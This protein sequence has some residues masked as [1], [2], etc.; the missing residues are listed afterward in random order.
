MEAHAEVTI[1]KRHFF[2]FVIVAF[3]S[4]N[5]FTDMD[6][7]KATKEITKPEKVSYVKKIFY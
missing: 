3:F 4:Y 2:I 1:S 5:K 6:T 7:H